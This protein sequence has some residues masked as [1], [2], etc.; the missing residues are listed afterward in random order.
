M[1]LELHHHPNSR[2]QRI[3]WLLEELQLEYDLIIHQ[4]H[5]S[6][7]SNQPTFKFPTLIFNEIQHTKILTETSAIAEFLCLKQQ[8][9]Y[10]QPH[11]TTYWSFCFYKHFADAS[12]M[13]NLA[14]KQVFA[15]IT[16]QTPWLVRFISLVF[17]TAFNKLHLNPELEKQL[18][19]LN[20]H[21]TNNLWLAGDVFTYADILLWFPLQ[22]SRYAY[23]DFSSY[24][25]LEKYL[26]QIESRPAFQEALQKG[27][28]SA[29][30]FRTY[31]NITR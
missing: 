1:K 11:D 20:V 23:S 30:K 10:V 13:H 27:L 2:S 5:L 31:W 16:Q 7:S 25:T 9:L 18:Q 29:E 24:A 21:L 17:K 22:A 19:V 26:T 3:V 15:Q 12:F 14:L 4:E 28:W 6:K 8:K